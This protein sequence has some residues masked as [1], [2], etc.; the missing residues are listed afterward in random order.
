MAIPPTA[1][2]WEEPMDP[3]DVVDYTIDTTPLLS[4][5]EDVAS[6]TVVPLAE[7]ELLGLEV[8][9]AEYAP[10]ITDNVILVWLQVDPA[11]Q[12]NPAFSGAGQTLPLEVSITTNS[13]PPR[14]RQRTV[15][16]KVMQR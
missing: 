16:V 6:Y 1:L 11:F 4:D 15:V 3:Y 2:V 9:T 13:S 14:K 12:A 8:G 7:S 5:L 10:S